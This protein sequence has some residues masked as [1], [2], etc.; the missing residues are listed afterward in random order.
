VWLGECGEMD[1][2]YMSNFMYL[3]V[4]VMKTLH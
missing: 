4:L 1:M 2:I 3:F